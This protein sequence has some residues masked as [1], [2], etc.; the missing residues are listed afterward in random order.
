LVTLR[1]VCSLNSDNGCPGRVAE[2]GLYTR[3]ALSGLLPKVG[4]FALVAVFVYV[5]TKLGDRRRGRDRGGTPIEI[6]DSTRGGAERDD[7]TWW[8]TGWRS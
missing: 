2:R 6:D 3:A 4:A 1:Y 8:P 5:A 7:E